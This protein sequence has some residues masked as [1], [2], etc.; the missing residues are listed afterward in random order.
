MIVIGVYTGLDPHRVG[1]IVSKT[2]FGVFVMKKVLICSIAALA[3]L[4]TGGTAVTKERAKNKEAD[5]QTKKTTENKKLSEE[6]K[7]FREQLKEMTP[8]QRRAAL[9]K[10]ALAE[11]LAPWQAV[12][13]IAA[14]EKATKTVAAIDKVIADRQEQFKKKL[15]AMKAEKPAQ[16][17]KAKAEGTRREGQK[18]ERKKKAQN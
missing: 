8:E 5:K 7:Q 6:E 18:T 12:R 3:I 10:K 13:K 2:N 15:E 4:L 16:A 14:E 1:S 11:E 9:A 17:D